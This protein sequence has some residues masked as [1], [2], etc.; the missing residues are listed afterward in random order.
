MLLSGL[1]ANPAALARAGPKSFAVLH[2]STHSF[3][4]DRI[5]ELSRIVLSLVDR[6]GQPVDGNL[7]P[8]QISGMQL[9]GSIVVLSSCETALGKEVPG[10]GLAGFR[11]SLFA[12]G[13]SQLVLTTGNVEAESSSA[14][15][16]EVY[17]EFFGARRVCMD[18]A[19]THARRILAASSRW[20]DPFYWA[21]YAVVGSP[22]KY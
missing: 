18:A 7:R 21:S 9:S 14:F 16:A 4:D 13:A 17:K 2:F 3:I 1:E 19:L 12:A 11:Q 22:C 20:S 6:N 5:P 10:E 15:F 8:Y